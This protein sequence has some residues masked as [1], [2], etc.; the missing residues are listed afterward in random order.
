VRRAQ[1]LIA[2]YSLLSY[3]KDMNL[4]IS[5]DDAVVRRAN[6]IADQRGVSLQQLLGEY[7]RTLA[8]DVPAET[9]AD[10]L[11]GLMNQQGGRSGG[12]PIK[13]ESAYE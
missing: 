3:H 5:V 8:T 11:I 2:L 9:V 1:A 10:E 12:R 13:R 6:A 7:L 4:N